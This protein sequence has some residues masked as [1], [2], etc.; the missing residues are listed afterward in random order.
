MIFSR[1]DHP[2][3]PMEQ[4]RIYLYANNLGLIWKANHS[5]IDPDFISSD[6]ESQNAGAGVQSQFLKRINMKLLSFIRMIFFL[7]LI[8]LAAGRCRKAFLAQKPSTDLLIPNSLDCLQELLDN[9]KV[10]NVTPALGEVSA[11]NYYLPYTTWDALDIK[12]SNAY[13]WATDL[14]EGQ[15]LVSDW[16]IPLSTG[17]LCQYGIAK[18][19]RDPD[20]IRRI[21]RNGTCLKVGPCFAG[22]LP[23][24]I[25]RSFL[26]SLYDSAS[27][28]S[29]LGIPIRLSPDIN[30]KTTRASMQASYTQILS[31][32]Q[33]AE[34]LLPAV[35]PAK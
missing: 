25:S 14:Y 17:L 3:L 31:D 1:A 30:G 16:D 18:F 11:D 32:L 24:S 10:M 4:L 5:G 20:R 12:E 2:K 6:A 9:R 28:A 26:P 13:I 19:G 27:A 15:G 22:P 35:I 7:V 33:V 8:G 23:F 21:R 29:D 34:E